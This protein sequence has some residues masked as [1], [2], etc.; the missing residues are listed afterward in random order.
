LKQ[1]NVADLLLGTAKVDI[2]PDK[3]M[4]LAGFAH[5]HGD[6]EGIN[7]PL[8]LKVWFFQQTEAS[9]QQR[10]ALLVQADLIMW[11]TER[12]AA[13]YR[14]LEDRWGLPASSVI[15]N[16]SHT[17]SGPVLND[18][19]N[20]TSSDYVQMIEAKLFAGI[21]EACLKLEPVI[22]ERG[23]GD[24]RIGINRRKIVNGEMSMAPNPEGPIDQEVSVIRFRSKLTNETK[25]VLFHYTC[26]P[27][28]TDNK[29]ISSEF[30]GVAMEHVEKAIG[31]GAIASYVQGCCGD[32]R[33][34]LI[35]DDAFFRGD[36]S[37][38]LRL[39]KQLS[40]VVLHVLGMPMEELS[41]GLIS[42]S[43]AEVM[44]PFEHV[45]SDEQLQAGSLEQGL[46]GDWSRKL[47]ENPNRKCPGLPLNMNL[48][49]ITDNLAFLAMNG[50]M[51]VEY[52]LFLKKL[53]PWRGVLPLGYSNGIIAYVPTAAQL[54]EGGYEAKESVWYIGL[55]S[56]FA[57][58]IEDLI[59]EA[60]IRLLREC[61]E[62][63]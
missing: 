17:H 33:P 14:H 1:L 26:H 49:T 54:A 53:Y 43:S 40:D 29:F 58:E 45:P 30:P 55:P 62:A 11:R 2:T 3:P 10:K 8:H 36:D 24:C 52:G 27:T 21:D 42:S 15:L 25:G 6:F 37:D 9:G 23:A 56:P 60:A 31:G 34:A 18:M 38:V 44:L 22:L 32:I 46:I 57:A 61:V 19:Q 39:G 48:V 59:R 13:I 20:P 16:A 63:V 35:K 7:H 4:P 28:T 51:S 50:E 47:L 41:P 5:R 12:M